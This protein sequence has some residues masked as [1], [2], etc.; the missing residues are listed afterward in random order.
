VY[1]SRLHFKAGK[2]YGYQVTVYRKNHVGAFSTTSS[3]NL[4]GLNKSC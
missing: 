2:C 4:S 1:H 3:A